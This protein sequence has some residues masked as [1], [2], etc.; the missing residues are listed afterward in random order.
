MSS[1]I[2]AFLIGFLLGGIIVFFYLRKLW[3]RVKKKIPEIERE[4]INQI[5]SG[6]EIKGDIII[7]N[8]VQEYIKNHD[9]EIKLGDVLEDEDR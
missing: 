1:I 7:N 3:Q 8:P 5:I 9:G 6:E 4:T 2:L